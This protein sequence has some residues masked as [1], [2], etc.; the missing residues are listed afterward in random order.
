MCVCMSA[1]VCGCV[2]ALPHN[3][4][5]LVQIPT[6]LTLGTPDSI[7]EFFNHQQSTSLTKTNRVWLINSITKQLLQL[8]HDLQHRGIC[9]AAHNSI[10]S[11][12]M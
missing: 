8:V 4:Y 6:I 1:S 7:K 3:N 2:D 5:N 9:V 11:E 10:N 12:P